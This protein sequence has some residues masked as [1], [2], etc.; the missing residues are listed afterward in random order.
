MFD[1]DKG[2]GREGTEESV[3]GTMNREFEEETGTA[4]NFA[5]EHHC[6]SFIDYKGTNVILTSV[7]CLVTSDLAFFSGILSGFH[8]GTFNAARSPFPFFSS[9]RTHTR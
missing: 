3:V 7:F 8:S 4:V 9:L 6:F 1:F 5:E 2:G